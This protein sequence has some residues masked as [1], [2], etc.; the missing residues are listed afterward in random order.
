MR[1]QVVHNQCYLF[2]GRPVVGYLPQKM[3]QTFLVLCSVTV[4]IRFP[5]KRSLAKKIEHTP[6]RRY[7]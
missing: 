3:S 5:A 2:S 4:T 7:S 6:Q 1:V